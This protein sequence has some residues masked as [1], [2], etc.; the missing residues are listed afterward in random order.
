MRQLQLAQAFSMRVQG[1]P[2][3]LQTIVF[4]FQSRNLSP[5]SEQQIKELQTLLGLA[6]NK[7]EVTVTFGVVQAKD[8]EIAI[9][10]RSVLQLLLTLAG[11]VDVPE[12]DTHD[13]RVLPARE[14]RAGT[15]GQLHIRYSRDKPTDAIAQVPYREG[16]FWIDDRDIES[17]KTF[18]LTMLLSTLT[19]TGAREALPLVTISSSG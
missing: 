12:S 15:V 13:N 2:K 8:D 7:N 4:V 19:E 18:G 14:I 1:D 16:W 11:S 3:A 5:T 6:L 10:T 17:K 9:Q